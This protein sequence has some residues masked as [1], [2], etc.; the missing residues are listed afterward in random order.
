MISTIFKPSAQLAAFPVHSYKLNKVYFD[1]R[2]VQIWEIFPIGG[3]RRTYWVQDML[4]SQGI[5]IDNGYE[6]AAIVRE[7][8]ENMEF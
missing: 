8:I 7:E 1:K 5:L 4:C 3:Y 2:N 6:E